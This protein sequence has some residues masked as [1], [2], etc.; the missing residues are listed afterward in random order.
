MVSRKFFPVFILFILVSC[1]EILL[2]NDISRE[3]IEILSPKNNT[4]VEAATIYFNWEEIEGATAYEIQ[5]ASPDFEDAQQIIFTEIVEETSF[6]E[7]VPPGIYEWRVRGINSG[8][9]TAFSSAKFKAEATEN[10]SSRQVSLLSPNQNYIT[11]SNNI[12]LEWQE[13]EG[14]SE[15]RIQ[16]TQ[17]GEVIKEET[18]SGTIKNIELPEGDLIWKVRAENQTQNTFYTGR[19]ILVDKTAPMKPIPTSPPNNSTT[20]VPTVTFEWTRNSNGGTVES[21]SLFIFKDA[22]L[23]NLEEK[24]KV[25]NSYTTSLERQETYYWYMR[26]YDQA[27][28]RS[29]R[30]EVFSFSI[31]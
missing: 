3:S 28:N 17:N 30:S 6:T 25:N 13:V 19:T 16:I 29:A 2:E 7:D 23:E 10:F 5:L 14:A 24:E 11:N 27:G 18:T 8:Y 9:N 1:E 21:D 31:N 22:A 20:S 12:T 26:A 15:Y 4:V